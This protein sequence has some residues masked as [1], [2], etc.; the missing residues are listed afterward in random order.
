MKKSNLKLF[1]WTGYDPDYYG[2]LAFAIAEDEISARELVEKERGRHYPVTN[3][4]ELEVRTLDEPIA[5][6][7]AGGG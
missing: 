1:I 4:G 7:L 6:Q 3:W 5:R 2:G